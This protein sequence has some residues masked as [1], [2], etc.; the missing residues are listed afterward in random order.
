MYAFKK[1]SL[2]DAIKDA[3]KSTGMTVASVSVGYIAEA[4]C[5]GIIPPLAPFVA[6]GTG[7]GTRVF[8]RGV[9]RKADLQEDISKNSEHLEALVEKCNCL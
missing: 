9:S 7:I 5:L 1:K 3:A 6:F 2:E 8:L 4:I